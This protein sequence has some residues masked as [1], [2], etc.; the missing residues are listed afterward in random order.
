M[1]SSWQLSAH[2]GVYSYFIIYI[3]KQGGD[4]QNT[5]Q[6]YSLGTGPKSPWDVKYVRFIFTVSGVLSN[7]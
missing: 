1:K 5:I 3:Y 7:T 6:G 2:E 4:I